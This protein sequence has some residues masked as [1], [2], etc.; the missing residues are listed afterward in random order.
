MRDFGYAVSDCTAIHPVFGTMAD[1]DLLLSEAHRRGLHVLL[2]LVPNHTS[3]EH[4]WFLESRSSLNNANRDWYIWRDPAPG[5]GPPNNWL[6][7]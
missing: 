4:P 5:G 1:F 2:D 7:H 6:S 3:D